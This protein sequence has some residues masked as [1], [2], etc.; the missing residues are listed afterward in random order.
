MTNEKKLE[1]MLIKEL[2]KQM[3]DEAKKEADFQDSKVDEEEEYPGLDGLIN[4]FKKFELDEAYKSAWKSDEDW[5]KTRLKEASNH[6]YGRKC[7][8][9]FP[10]MELFIVGLYGMVAR[11]RT[12]LDEN[13]FLSIINDNCNLINDLY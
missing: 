7:S 4:P 3:I 1:E 10:F 9:N 13:E 8:N 5:L 2:V 11:I 6:I 12:D